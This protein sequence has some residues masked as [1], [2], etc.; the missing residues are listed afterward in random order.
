VKFFQTIHEGEAIDISAPFGVW[1]HE[2][3]YKRWSWPR[4]WRVWKYEELGQP[5]EPIGFAASFTMPD[6]RFGIFI[7]GPQQ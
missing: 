3:R 5:S 6:H 1:H 2:G 4:V 7:R